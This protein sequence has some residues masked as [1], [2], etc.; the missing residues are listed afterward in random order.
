M[1]SSRLDTTIVVI[2]VQL[3]LQYMAQPKLALS[4]VNHGRVRDS[5][6]S[7]CYTWPI[8]YCY[9]FGE[10]ESLSLIVYPPLNQQSSI[11]NSKLVLIKIALF[12]LWLKH[13]HIHV[14][15]YMHTDMCVYV[16]TYICA[17]NHTY[18]TCAHTIIH[19]TYICIHTCTH[20]HN[21]QNDKLVTFLLLW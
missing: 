18:H 5:W 19:V 16:N 21:A 11:D 15:V 2:N 13:N 17:H 8:G 10:E 12:K 9:L 3:Q 4:A 7:T 6:Y 20:I 1:P 14:H